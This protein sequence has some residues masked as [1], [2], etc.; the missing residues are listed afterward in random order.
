MDQY[1]GAER[2]RPPEGRRAGRRPKVLRLA[3]VQVCQMHQLQGLVVR[4]VWALSVVAAEPVRRPMALGLAAQTLVQQKA[5]RI[6]P[7]QLVVAAGLQRESK[8]Q[9]VDQ[10]E[11]VV[12]ALVFAGFGRRATAWE[13]PRPP[14]KEQR[15][16]RS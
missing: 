5:D 10:R 9:R 14:Q 6:Q 2:V 3:V 16:V 7:A 1:G 12:V 4:M 13:R 11:W 15:A 8:G